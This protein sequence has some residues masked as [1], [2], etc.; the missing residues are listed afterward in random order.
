MKKPKTVV[1]LLAVTYVCI[2][3]SEAQ[4]RHLENHGKGPSRKKDD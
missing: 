1:D 3:T 4:A 2:K